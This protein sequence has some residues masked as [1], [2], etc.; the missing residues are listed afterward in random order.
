[1]SESGSPQHQHGERRSPSP[2]Q[3]SMEEGGVDGGNADDDGPSSLG[4]VSEEIQY[5]DDDF[6]DKDKESYDRYLDR[7]AEPLFRGDRKQKAPSCPS[8]HCETTAGIGSTEGLGISAAS[9]C[10]SQRLAVGGREAPLRMLAGRR[11]RHDAS[12]AA[13]PARHQREDPSRDRA[14]PRPRVPRGASAQGLLLGSA[15][16]STSL[17]PTGRLRM[18]CECWRNCT[19]NYF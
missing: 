13:A 15:R 6:Y 14:I 18:L 11:Q 17:S 2:P 12:S 3:P 16:P 8:I 4:G 9:P 5:A 19:Q 1:M 10:C 7:M